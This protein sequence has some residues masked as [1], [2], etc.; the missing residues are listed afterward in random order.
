MSG[1]LVFF[2]KCTTSGKF[3]FCNVSI[4]RDLTPEQLADGTRNN[5]LSDR[6]V[7]G[8]ILYSGN[9]SS[10]IRHLLALIQND[11]GRELFH[12]HTPLAAYSGF[13]KEMHDLIKFG[14]SKADLRDFLLRLPIGYVVDVVNTKNVTVIYWP[15]KVNSNELLQK[16]L[17]YDN[18]KGYKVTAD[19]PRQ[20]CLNRAQQDAFALLG[21]VRVPGQATLF[22]Y[23]IRII[24]WLQFLDFLRN[25]NAHRTKTLKWM[26]L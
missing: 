23:H 3:R 10:E 2:Q 11:D 16:T 19:N 17:L 8:N 1:F 18:T 12:V 5:Y 20:T 25:R 13:F 7:I 21:L 6:A 15:N 24:R 9:P 4:R 14:L 22:P 26:I